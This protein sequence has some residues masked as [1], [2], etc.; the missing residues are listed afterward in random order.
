MAGA[1]RG[2]NQLSGSHGKLWWNKNLIAEINKFD[3]KASGEREDVVVGMDIDSK[4]T[5]IKCEGSLEFK[6]IFSR[7]KK[8]IVDAW[9]KGEDIRFD[10]FVK[11]DDPDAIGK[12]EESWSIGNVWFN[13]FPIAVFE[14]KQVMNEEWSFG[15]TFSDVEMMS[16]I[17]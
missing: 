3:L 8:D 4:L 5:A 15:C 2:K 10:L 13:D 12:Q 7:Y 14:S 9:K 6:K 17:K 11:V 1:F 16:E